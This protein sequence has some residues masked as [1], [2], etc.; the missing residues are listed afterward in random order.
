M[1]L[2]DPA[3]NALECARGLLLE[4]WGL[5]ESHLSGALGEIFTHQADYADL[6]F[7][8]TRSEGWA[9][10]EGIVK[11]GSFSIE[12]GVGVRALSGEKTAF[13]YS[14]SL[15]PEALLSSARVVR[16]IARQGGSG[17][18]GILVPADTQRPTL[19]TG[20]DP[21]ASLPAPEKV[22]LL[23]RLDALAR[24][25]DSRVVQVMAS[26]G[27]EYDVILVAGSDGRLKGAAHAR[28]QP[29]DAQ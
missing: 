12:Q 25:A 17:K 20:T 10:D 21:I 26:L 19:Y 11:S 24:A 27:A 13:A 18:S 6:Y 28:L 8:Y 5:N 7:Q 3:I 15:S 16:S 9:L 4:P 2:V 1:K 22:A 29:V 23:G 14:D